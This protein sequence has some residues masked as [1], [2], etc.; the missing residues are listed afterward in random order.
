[1]IS[2]STSVHAA[3]PISTGA[4]SFTLSLTVTDTSVTPNCSSTCTKT[5]TVNAKPNCSISGGDAV[6]ASSLG[7]TYTGPAGPNRTWS[8][9][10]KI[11]RAH[12]RTT[13]THP[14]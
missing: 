14:S 10:I 12:N 9:S 6:C 4:G 8:W 1:T 3:L 5:V 13:Q 7:N 2:G 11:G